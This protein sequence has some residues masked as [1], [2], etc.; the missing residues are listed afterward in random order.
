MSARGE[1]FRVE[2]RAGEVAAAIGAS[3]WTLSLRPGTPSSDRER[4][5][6]APPG[7]RAPR[8][9]KTGIQYIRRLHGNGRD[10]GHRKPV[11]AIL[12]GCR[13]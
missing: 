3:S 6:E 8:I 1:S 12:C 11:L 4:S 10:T 13:H 9:L 2:V 5:P 7:P